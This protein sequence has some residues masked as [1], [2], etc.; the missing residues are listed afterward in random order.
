V[1]N[2]VQ[3][4][5]TIV[6]NPE[7]QNIKVIGTRH[8]FNYIADTYSGKGEGAAAVHVCLEKFTDMQFFKMADPGVAGFRPAIKFGAGITFS[9]LIEEVD[10]NGAAIEN[11]PS[12]PHI[13]VTGAIITATHGSG[14]KNPIHADMVEEFEMMFA[15]GSV[16]SF[17]KATSPYFKHYLLTMGGIGIF[18]SMTIR[19]V[20]TFNVS[21]SIYQN[22][23]WDQLAQNQD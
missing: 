19:L 23:S 6:T 9:K 16:K 21:K 22:L 13:N 7:V 8:S 5:K 18:I 14:H 20:P 15:D 10:R 11:L 1:P 2:N 3:E 12:L 17:N 4:L